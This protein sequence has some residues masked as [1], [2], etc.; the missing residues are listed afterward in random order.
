MS[1]IYT[2]LSECVDTINVLSRMRRSYPISLET[3]LLVVGKNALQ[4]PVIYLEQNFAIPRIP[5]T[6]SSLVH[7]VNQLN[8]EKK[9]RYDGILATHSSITDGI[10]EFVF[11]VGCSCKEQIRDD[12]NYYVIDEKLIEEVRNRWTSGT[13]G[14]VVRGCLGLLEKVGSWTFLQILDNNK[15]L[16]TIPQTIPPVL[17]LV[18]FVIIVQNGKILLIKEPPHKG[19][20][21]Y[22]PA[23]HFENSEDLIT[24]AKR[25]TREEAGVEV[26]VDK[27]VQII[28]YWKK[29]LDFIVTANV[30]GGELKKHADKESQ[31]AEWFDLDTVIREVKSENAKTKYRNPEELSYFFSFIFTEKHTI[32]NAIP[33]I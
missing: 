9:V 33:I 3:L 32:R 10:N 12:I 31:G 19:G 14:A 18:V 24:A 2:E 21:W 8:L 5:F 30:V 29:L 27:I 22:I 4:Q 20:G 13:K 11:V 1:Q 17:D 6:L 15:F 16:T 7:H 25:E 28:Y 26:N 23:G